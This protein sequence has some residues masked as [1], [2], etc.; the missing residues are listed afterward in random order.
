MPLN[1]LIPVLVSAV[2]GLVG[3]A[4]ALWKRRD[5]DSLARATRR[6][7]A[8]QLLSDE[9]FS[10]MLVLDECIAVRGLVAAGGALTLTD[11]RATEEHPEP[12]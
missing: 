8:L 11:S 12:A 4:L 1:G 5:D 3:I 6:T 7:T 9:E 10:L 2:L